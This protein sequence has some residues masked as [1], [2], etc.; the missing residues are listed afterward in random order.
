MALWV[1]SESH[2]ISSAYDGSVSSYLLYS[3]FST[4]LPLDRPVSLAWTELDTYIYLCVLYYIAKPPL[5]LPCATPFPLQVM[6][7]TLRVSSMLR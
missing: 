7:H 6:S 4:Q 1:Q 5:I 2:R 3:T